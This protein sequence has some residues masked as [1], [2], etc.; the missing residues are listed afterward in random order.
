M[1]LFD[2]SGTLLAENDDADDSPDPG[3]GAL[4]Y[5]DSFIDF[6]FSSTDLFV[7]G[8][9]KFQSSA[10][11][12]SISGAAPEDDDDYQLQV[13]IE[14]HTVGMGSSND[15]G[16]VDVIRNQLSGNNGGTGRELVVENVGYG[17]ICLLF[18]D[19]NSQNTVSPGQFNFDFLNT[20]GGGFDLFDFN[21][22]DNTG[23]VGS[24]DGSVVIP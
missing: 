12:G 18:D 11:S 4:E 6:T 3:D 8:V 10:D 17:T 7:I 2:S 13:S 21:A 23:T 14:N 22:N 1:F 16:I 9:G 19:N 15:L 5:L 20:G 24:S